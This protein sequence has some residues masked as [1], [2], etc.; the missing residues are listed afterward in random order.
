[1]NLK[2]P[3]TI[4]STGFGSGLSPLAPGTVGS[5]FASIIYYILFFENI[6]VLVDFIIFFTFIIFS[7]LLGLYIY[8]KTVEGQ[9]DPASFVWDEFVGMWVACIP[10]AVMNDSFFWL[11]ISFVLF[12][13]F[14]ILKPIGI[15]KL[16]KKHG[17]FFVMIDDVLAGLLAAIIVTFLSIFFI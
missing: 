9:N 7:F 3:Y 4:I 2:S 15:K 11:V 6:T 5:F 14:D 10:L 8:P 1:M 13:I 17:A 12:R 16:D